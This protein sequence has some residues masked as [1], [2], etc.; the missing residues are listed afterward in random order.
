MT[1]SIRMGGVFGM[2]IMKFTLTYDG[3][4]PASANGSSKKVPE[5]QEIREHISP[6]LAELWRLHPALQRAKRNRYVSKSGAFL[7]ADH[8]HS[9]KLPP[10][11]VDKNSIDLCAEV[12]LGG[13]KFMPLVRSSYNTI[14][15]ISVL[16][17]RQEAAGS[18]YQGGDLDNRIKT[19][20]DALTLPKAEHIAKAPPSSSASLPIHC[21]M[22]DDSLMAGLNVETRRL[23]THPG[24]D[25][26]QVRLIIEVD[27]RVPDARSYNT[28][29]LGD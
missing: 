6:Q 22:E 28:L 7:T 14:C 16:F 17:L 18:V 20:L 25:E 29:F 15:G 5:K 10:G 1:V 3:I 19:L 21:L 9:V 23:L 27:V 26:K 24:A 11:T 4:L 8:H 13:V 2:S 12:E